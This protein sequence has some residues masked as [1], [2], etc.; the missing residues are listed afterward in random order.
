MPENDSTQNNAGYSEGGRKLVHIGLGLIAFSLGWLP[1]PVAAAVAFAAILFNWLIL[2]RIG[3]RK[4][5]RSS[6]GSART[7]TDATARDSCRKDIQG[8]A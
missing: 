4:I 1:W 3:G 5:S 2:P 6:A 7:M 8:G